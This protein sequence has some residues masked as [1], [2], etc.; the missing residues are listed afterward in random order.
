MCKVAEVAAPNWVSI[1]RE[2]AR[3][4]QRGKGTVGLLEETKLF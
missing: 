2:S 1:E 3:H 4:L